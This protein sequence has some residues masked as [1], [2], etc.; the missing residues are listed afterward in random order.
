MRLHLLHC[1]VGMG[2][3]M[4]EVLG[5]KMA[6]NLVLYHQGRNCQEE[7]KWLERGFGG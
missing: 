1:Y 6:E 4:V 7:G 3:E 2:R 5:W